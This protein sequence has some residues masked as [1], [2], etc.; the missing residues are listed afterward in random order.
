MAPELAATDAAS[1][2]F[3]ITERIRFA[4]LDVLG[5]VNNIAFT[6]Y[7]E[8]C[9]AAFLRHIGFWTPQPGERQAVL[10]HIELDYRRELHYPGDVRV[11]LVVLHIGGSSVRVGLGLFDGG[12][13]AATAQ[14]VL[15]RIERGSRRPTALN[16]EERASLAPYL[17]G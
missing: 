12:H 16:A 11:G 3:W 5:H 9:R 13:C 17:R 10:A 6:V 15:V 7:A 1:Y 2:K 14:A 8:S 4:D